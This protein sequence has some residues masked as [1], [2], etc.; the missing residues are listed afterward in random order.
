ME[1]EGEEGRQGCPPFW[2]PKYATGHWMYW[3]DGVSACGTAVNTINGCLH[4]RTVWYSSHL[5]IK[6]LHWLQSFGLYKALGTSLRHDMQICGLYT[7]NEGQENA[8][9]SHAPGKLDITQVRCRTLN[10]FA[11]NLFT[12]L[13]T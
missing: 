2:N 4:R 7:G 10:H 9:I 11:A 8:K 1:R 6:S 12:K 3:G 5:K 13:Y